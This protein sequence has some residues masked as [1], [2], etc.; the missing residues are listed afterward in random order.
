MAPAGLD[1]IVVLAGAVSPAQFERPYPLPDNESF[2]RCQHAAWVYRNTKL[3]VLVSGGL[4]IAGTPPF[5]VT[6]REGLLSA[7]VPPEMI[8]IEDRSRSTH[9]N[10]LFS[11]QILQQHKA[12]RIALVVDARSMLRA[13][14]CFREGIEVVAAPSH[15]RYISATVEEWIPGWKAVQG[16]ELTLHETLGLLWY[17]MRGWI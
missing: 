1:A 4:G 2:R 3:P 14:A 15:F 17:R 7:G 12:R 6:M 13:S 9:E 5:A 8:W 11:T 10:A 16:N